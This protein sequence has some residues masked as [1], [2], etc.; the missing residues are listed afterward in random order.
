VTE[1]DYI[2]SGAI[3]ACVMGLANEEDWLELEQMAAL[4]PAVKEAQLRIELE[5]EQQHLSQ[6]VTPP[7]FLKQKI[8][9]SL[10]FT[11]KDETPVVAIT[12]VS[13][14][15]TNAKPLVVPIVPVPK[16]VRWLQRVVAASVILLMGSILLNFHFYS[17]SIGIKKD[18]DAL[19]LQQNT[20][21]TKNRAMEASFNTLKDPG[22]KPVKMTGT[23]SQP[24]S[25]ATVYW[26]TRSKDVYL[27]VNNLP[28]PAEGK[29]YQLWAIV[30]G[31]PVD[32]GMVEMSPENLMLKMH[33]MPDAQAFAITLEK[34][35]GSPAPTMEAMYVYGTAI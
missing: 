6:P 8:L 21:L 25:L 27:M 35:G 11:E 24:S 33:N 5:L 15:P 1:Q 32:A 30:N 28:A 26:D 20:L 18:Y 4:Y 9:H 23:P 29:Q 16:S 7:S 14:A 12:D 19:V 2:S 13:A 3:E 17:K 10:D 31:K 22:M 34:K